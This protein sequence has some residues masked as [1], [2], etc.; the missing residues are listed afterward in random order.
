MRVLFIVI[1]LVKLTYLSYSQESVK[2]LFGE[3]GIESSWYGQAEFGISDFEGNK[4]LL[5]SVE[6]GTMLNG[7]LGLGLGV[8]ANVNN[9]Q[10]ANLDEEYDEGIFKTV[11][12]GLVITP[13]FYGN[14]I[15]HFSTPVLIGGGMAGY[16]TT[17]KYTT[18]SSGGDTRMKR[19]VIDSQGFF[20]LEPSIVGELNISEKLRF[21]MGASYRFAPGME[22]IYTTGGEFNGVV[23]KTGFIIGKR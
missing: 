17:R 12:G 1:L 6:G 4:L 18:I 3:N 14:S 8:K 13:V 21:F 2:T 15:V 23:L 10:Y 11:Y 19:R 5:G 20:V 16:L 9:P 7:V 22:M